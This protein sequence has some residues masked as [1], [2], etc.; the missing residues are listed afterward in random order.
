[1]RRGILTSVVVMLAGVVL[2]AQTFTPLTAWANL[3]GKSD[4]N[5]SVM[6]FMRAYGGSVGPLTPFANL[7]VRTDSNGS[8]ATTVAGGV[9]TPDSLCLDAANQDVGIARSAANNLKVTNC[10]AT[11]YATLGSNGLLFPTDNTYDIGASGATRPRDLNAG[12]NVVAGSALIGVTLAFGTGSFSD[13]RSSADKLFTLQNSGVTTGMEIT[14]GSATLGTCTGG[15]IT[16]GSHN[17][18][19]GYTGNTSG[20]CIVN[21]G[22]PNWTN[23]PF[24]LAMSTASTTHP[25]VSAVS[26]SSMTITGGVSGEAITYHCDGRI[27]T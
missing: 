20:S 25:R 17:F 16:A 14:L 15:T 23:A 24:C 21:F 27:G 11:T 2:Y 22:S 19:G 13:F 12:R 4:N 6:A 8:L 9:A 5:G 3:R 18:G 26:T 10:G 1:M 7:L